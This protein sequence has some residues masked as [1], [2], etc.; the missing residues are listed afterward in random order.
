M[1]L[2]TLLVSTCHHE[3]ISLPTVDGRVKWQ[4]SALG[5]A[6]LRVELFAVELV[7]L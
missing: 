3:Q 6:V 2:S 7:K 4:A 5:E 1:R